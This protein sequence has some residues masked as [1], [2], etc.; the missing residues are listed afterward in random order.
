MRPFCWV[1]HAGTSSTKGIYCLP[2]STPDRIQ[3]VETRRD[4]FQSSSPNLKQAF[5]WTQSKALDSFWYAE[6]LNLQRPPTV[7]STGFRP[8]SQIPQYLEPSR[9][10]GQPPHHEKET[11]CYEKGAV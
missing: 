1:A 5:L 11:E 3:D 2:A 10:S 9:L 8:L 6:V 7:R 4:G